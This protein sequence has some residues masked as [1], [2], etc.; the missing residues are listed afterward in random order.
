MSADIKYKKKKLGSYPYFLV[1][2][3][4]IFSLTI[5]GFWISML[6]MGDQL[7]KT[8]KEK[9]SIQ[10]YLHK[11][12]SADSI[13]KIQKLVQNRPYVLQKD[14]MPQVLFISKEASAKKFIEE[15]GENFA[16]FMGENP[17]RDAFVINIDPAYSKSEQLA[18]I[19]S[20]L[21]SQGG[22]FEVSYIEGLADAIHHNIQRLSIAAIAFTSVMIVVIFLLINNTIK[23]AMY[24]QRFLIRSMQLV[25][26]KSWFIQKPYLF[27]S[28]WL[29]ML[30]G[31]VAAV[32]ILAILQYG[33]SYFP[34]IGNL[35][36][37][38]KEFILLGGLI[39]GGGMICLFSSLLAVSRYLG[40]S[41]EEL[42]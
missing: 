8:I 24:S 3:S 18:R 27:R 30:G 34:E 35:L 33:K 16:D 12:L 28:M 36:F 29:G 38:E 40:K 15:T 10:V 37:I 22:I 2:F 11:E 41:L 39:L 1:L 26:A 23:L 9:I 42:Y 5:I 19:K 25:G 4:L 17:L 31:F 20:D 13:Q 32:I 6:L 21:S 14:G 7:Q